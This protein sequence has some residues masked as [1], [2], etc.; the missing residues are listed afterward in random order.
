MFKCFNNTKTKHISFHK[1]ICVNVLR[2]GKIHWRSLIK[3]K[4]VFVN[5]EI[6]KG[7]LRKGM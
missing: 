3:L 6:L 4:K 2:G 5:K 1:T 7:E